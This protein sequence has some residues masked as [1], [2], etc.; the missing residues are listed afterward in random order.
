MSSQRPHRQAQS[1]SHNEPPFPGARPASRGQKWWLGTLLLIVFA[2]LWWLLPLALYR[3]T[4]S[5]PES[6]LQAVTD[7]RAAF[8]AGLVG[9][10]ALLTFWVNRRTLHV[11]EQGHVTDRYTKAVGQLGASTPDVRVGGL[12]AL[13]RLMVESPEDHGAIIDVVEAFLREHA[14]IQPI[15][16]WRQLVDRLTKKA[17]RKVRPASD[18]QAALNVLGYRPSRSGAE[19]DRL[20]LADTDLRGALLREV[21]FQ[22]VN[23]RHARLNDAHLQGAHLEH[24]SLDG[25]QLINAHLRGAHLTDADFTGAD[26]RGASGLSAAQLVSAKVYS[27]TKLDGALSKD[28]RVQARVRECDEVAERPRA[29]V[30]R[31]LPDS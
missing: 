14:A 9:L 11:T 5:D 17:P 1:A 2:L 30:P 26:L 19:I 4:G 12:Y 8:L 31:S 3:H 21:A 25:A 7:T 10:G 13:R 29:H 22:K 20:R 15:R 27:S 6:K 24:A 23:L 18:V 16:S 28:P